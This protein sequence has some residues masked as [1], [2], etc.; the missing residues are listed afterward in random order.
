MTMPSRPSRRSSGRPAAPAPGRT[1]G[2]TLGSLALALLNRLRHTPALEQD[3]AGAGARLAWS[4]RAEIVV[5]A[6]AFYMA[7]E[8]VSVHPI[9]YGHRVQN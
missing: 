2:R 9:D 8:M 6:I 7:A 1:L 4:I 5:V 3:R